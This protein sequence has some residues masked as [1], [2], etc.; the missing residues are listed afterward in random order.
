MVVTENKNPP[1]AGRGA[2]AARPVRA[3]LFDLDGT[4]V[5][6]EMHT[7]AAISAVAAQ[8]GIPGFAL[9]HT[10]T[11]GRTWAFVA[12]TIRAR[13]GIEVAAEVIAAE[14][15]AHWND[16]AI[17]VQ[18]IPGAPQALRAAA[19]RKLRLGVVSSSPRSVIDSFLDKLG[20]G[21]LIDRRARIGGDEVRTTKPDPEGFLLAS[22]ALGVEPAAT[23]VFEDSHAGLLAAR[24]AGMRSVFVTC[25]AA[26]V[27]GNIALA[28][29]SCV[30]YEVL[31]AN[32]WDELASGTLDL[33]NRSF[34]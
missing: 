26:D 20:V 17:D 23:L 7:D 32:F 22:R 25:C 12:D 6:S 8:Y 21:D 16:A 5:D 11:R 33:A 4:L 19:A 1:A 31:P 10:E 24:A 3:V 34:T 29:A 13:T 30:H 18:P 2:S 27:A 14:L 28:T 15:L 9:P